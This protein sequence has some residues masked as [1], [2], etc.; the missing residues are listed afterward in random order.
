ME[1]IVEVKNLTKVYQLYNKPI[2]R[3]KEAVRIPRKVYHT[4]FYA[5]KDISFDVKKGE[6]IGIIGVNGSGKS[7]LLKIITGVLSKTSGDIKINGK[8]SALLELGAGFN[9]DYTGIENIYM[10][11]L[12]MGF[13]KEEMDNKLN[14]ILEFADIG[15]FVYRPVKQY[16]SGMFV[17][18]AFSLSIAVEPDILIVDEALSVGDIFFQAKCYKRMNELKEKGTTIIM[19]THDLGAVIKYCDRVVLLNKGVKVSE[20][21]PHEIIDLYKKILAGKF[22]DNDINVVANKDLNVG[23]SSESPHVGA[24]N[25]QTVVAN[26]DLNVGA[27]NVL[28]VGASSASPTDWKSEMN[29]NKD[30]NIYG[31]DKAEIIDYGIFDNNDKLSSV[32]VKGENF[33]IKEKILIKE[34]IDSPIFTFTIKDKRGTEITGT[35]TMFEGVD[36]GIGEKGKI[37]EV[38]FSQN[39]NLQGGEYLLSMSCTSFSDNQFVVHHRMYD[40]LSI[41]VISNKNTVGVYDMN[42]KVKVESK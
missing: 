25:N 14:T 24:N 19:V 20:G 21:T 26:N 40:I 29:V 27:N 8:I 3:L 9:M 33:S 12:M 7:T 1:N 16:S 32:I 15:D 4:D 37:Y 23:A 10:N 42:S 34:K 41:T 6:S 35:N 36:T 28:N 30:A 31:D 17:R 11:G 18:L 2:D 39:M 38:T 13:T 5:L 22:D